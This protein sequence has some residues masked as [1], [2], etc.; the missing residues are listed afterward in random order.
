MPVSFSSR[1]SRRR[2]RIS[3]CSCS[4]RNP[5]TGPGPKR[6][7]RFSSTRTPPTSMRRSRTF[8]GIILALAI[9]F[10]RSR[11]DRRLGGPPIWASSKRCWPPFPMNPSPIMPSAII[12][13]NWLMARS[14]IY[15][16]SKFGKVQ[17]SEFS[18]VDEMRK[19][20]ISNIHRLRRCRQKGLVIQFSD[21]RFDPDIMDFV[22]I[23]KGSLGGKARGARV[24]LQPP[25]PD[26]RDPA[27][28]PR[29]QYRCSPDH[30]D[31]HR[32]FRSVRRRQ[33][34]R[35]VPDLRLS[36]RGDPG[37]VSFGKISR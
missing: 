29:R 19:Y 5:R 14:E 25:A 31:R 9:W 34:T 11:I 27:A 8:S 20:I 36:G 1:R 10:S 4:A 2:C 26:P 33:R 7:R 13:S 32:R 21:R 30:G 37:A 6:F 28:V 15:L 3:P 23:G 22:K 12:F 24:Y 16:A 18:T 17:A 35:F